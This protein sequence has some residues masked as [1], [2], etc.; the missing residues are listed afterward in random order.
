MTD[1]KMTAPERHLITPLYSV[2][3][4]F[5]P[6][7]AADMPRE[8][9]SQPTCGRA[10]P[11]LPPGSP[12]RARAPQWTSKAFL[13]EFGD[14]FVQATDLEGGRRTSRSPSTAPWSRRR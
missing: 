8:A 11:G 10:R 6:L 5:F 3:L 12:T 4:S 2:S 9:D 7:P 14:A 1:E 13:G